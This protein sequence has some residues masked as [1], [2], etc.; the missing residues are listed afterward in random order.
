MSEITKTFRKKKNIS[1]LFL[2][3]RQE[4]LLLKL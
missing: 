4:T 1:K 3:S 2:P